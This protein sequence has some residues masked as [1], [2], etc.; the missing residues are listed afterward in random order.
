MYKLSFVT[1]CCNNVQNLENTYYKNVKKYD[2]NDDV[3]F[4][5]IYYYEDDYSKL[6]EYIVTNL[7]YELKTKK[8][9]YYKRK[10]TEKIN[11]NTEKNITQQLAKGQSIYD[12]Y[13]DKFLDGSE[14]NN[15]VKLNIE[16]HNTDIT[17]NEYANYIKFD[18]DDFKILTCFSVLYK[19]NQFIDNLINDILTQS[20]FNNIFFILINMYQTNSN[21][22]NTKIKN[23]ES[24]KN[25]K[26]INEM[27]DYGLY[28]MWNICIKISK[29]YLVSN[30][31]PDDIRGPEWACHQIKNFEPGIVLVTPKYIP[32]HKIVNYETLINSKFPKWYDTKYDI[33][34]SKIIFKGNYKY[35]NSKNLFQRVNTQFVSNN[36]VNCSPVWKKKE[37][38]EDNNYFDENKFGCYADMVVWL[39]AG[40]KYVFKQTDYVVGF[41]I[42]NKQLHRRQKKSEEVFNLLVSKYASKL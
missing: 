12:L 17:K 35:F 2:S 20:I 21:E 41:Y 37:I 36:V 40:S 39:E 18:I 32:A 8:L 24:Y 14:Y 5:L 7:F 15:S 31:N 30:L 27:N 38:H 3:E 26:I 42:S 28:N 23:L 6:E 1:L 4:I 34:N 22:T 9:K 25:I 33:I 13:A 16:L 29:T 10:I 19:S 11:L